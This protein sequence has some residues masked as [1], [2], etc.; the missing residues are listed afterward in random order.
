[1]HAKMLSYALMLYAQDHGG[2]YPAYLSELVPQYIAASDY[3]LYAAKES[4]KS[5]PKY[6]WLYFAAGRN[7]KYLPH[8]TIASPQAVTLGGPNKRTVAYEEAPLAS[9]EK[10]STSGNCL[11]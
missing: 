3:V 8:I 7:E 4:G 10:T 2:M 9:F 1:M 5:E 6:D 11:K